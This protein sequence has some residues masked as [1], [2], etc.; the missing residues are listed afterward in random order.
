MR[1]YRRNSRT[2][3]GMRPGADSLAVEIKLAASHA[4]AGDLKSAVGA[5]LSAAH[6]FGFLHAKGELNAHE[7]DGIS[8]LLNEILYRRIYPN[9]H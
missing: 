6:D 8:D 5:L 3:S 7:V 1:N 4:D 2:S 9:I